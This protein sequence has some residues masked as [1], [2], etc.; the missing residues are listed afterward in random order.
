MSEALAFLHNDAKIFHGNISP[1]SV[2]VNTRG[3]WK[4]A[5]FDFC[6]LGTPNAAGKTTFEVN[7]YDRSMMSVMQ[8]SLDFASPELISGVKCGVYVDVFSLGMLA[9]SL[10]N[11]C[12][13]IL[14][15]KGLL[16]TY[17]TKI[18]SVS[19]LPY[20]LYMLPIC[21]NLAVSN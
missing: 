4:L 10:F 8:P 16:D 1:S 9:C 7:E 18:E 12:R 17:K 15:A 5:G 19:L 20:L 13:P 21:S 2:I 6:V 11:D 3:A 14:A